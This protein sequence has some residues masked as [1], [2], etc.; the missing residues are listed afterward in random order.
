MSIVSRVMVW[1]AG[2]SRPAKAFLGLALLLYIPLLLLRQLLGMAITLDETKVRE[3]YQERI[4]LEMQS[5]VGDAVAD[6]QVKK[7]F[8]E[9]LEKL[10]IATGT[11]LD[12]AWVGRFLPL[13]KQAVPFEPSDLWVFGPDLKCLH[14]EGTPSFMREKARW[15]FAALHR[16]LWDVCRRDEDFRQTVLRNQGLNEYQSQLFVEAIN[17]GGMLLDRA[18]SLAKELW[19]EREDVH[20]MMQDMDEDDP[21]SILSEIE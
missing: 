10:P 20:K 19:S 16:N 4:Q 12:E 8:N 14:L 17:E 9:V 1:F 21:E 2:W 7:A 11:A 15:I 18:R 3:D 5:F 6:S 13:L